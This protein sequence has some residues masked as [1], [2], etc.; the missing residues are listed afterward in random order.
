MPTRELMIDHVVMIADGPA[1]ATVVV[2]VRALMAN[3][4]EDPSAAPAS[5]NGPHSR[6]SEPKTMPMIPNTITDV[7]FAGP[8][9]TWYASGMGSCGGGSGG[10]PGGVGDGSDIAACYRRRRGFGYGTFVRVIKAVPGLGPLASRMQFL[11][12]DR[13]VVRDVDRLGEFAFR[14]RRHRWMLGRP[15]FSSGHH[16][17]SIS[18]FRAMIRPGDVVYDIGANIGYYAG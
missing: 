18:T 5:W 10:K 8:V 17:E 15:L 4:L 7:G 2:A 14:L 3:E 13:V 9:G 1:V 16:A 12:P 11:L 6:P